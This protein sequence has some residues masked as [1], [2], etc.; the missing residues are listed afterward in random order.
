MIVCGP[1]E[2]PAAKISNEINGRSDSLRLLLRAR[3]SRQNGLSRVSQTMVDKVLTLP[4][5]KIGKRVG[6]LGNSLMIREQAK[7]P[8]PL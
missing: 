1:Y 5:E 7:V 4:R 6:H 2:L 8:L 3:S